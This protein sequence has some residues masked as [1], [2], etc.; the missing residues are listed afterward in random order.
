[1]TVGH[2]ENIHHAE[3]F[4]N[5]GEKQVYVQVYQLPKNPK[6]LTLLII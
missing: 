2:T 6:I 4:T 3:E 5:H 1:M